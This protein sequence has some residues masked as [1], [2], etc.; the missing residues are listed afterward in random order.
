[1]SYTEDVEW[2]L[3]IPGGA[4][5]AVGRMLS[6]EGVSLTHI[7]AKRDGAKVVLAVLAT[8]SPRTSLYRWMSPAGAW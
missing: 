1:M 6:G 8:R 3:K 4:G 7:T 2:Q 5:K